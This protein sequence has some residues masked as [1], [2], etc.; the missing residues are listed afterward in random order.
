MQKRHKL[1]QDAEKNITEE[2]SIKIYLT[3]IAH[4]V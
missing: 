4:I 3:L 2:I 1:T